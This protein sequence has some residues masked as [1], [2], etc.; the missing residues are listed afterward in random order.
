MC[1][2]VDFGLSEENRVMFHD[3]EKAFTMIED[4][5]ENNK[6]S[7]KPIHTSKYCYVRIFYMGESIVRSTVPRR[8]SLKN[9]F[10]HFKA[11]VTKK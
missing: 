8:S 3:M 9:D 4:H 6:K 10:N 11:K 7:V 5:W 1:A 2:Y